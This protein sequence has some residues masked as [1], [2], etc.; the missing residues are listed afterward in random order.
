MTWLCRGAE[1]TDLPNWLD[2]VRTDD[3]TRA[4]EFQWLLLESQSVAEQWDDAKSDVI[5]SKGIGR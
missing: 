2:A 4:R 1:W 5:S 3:S